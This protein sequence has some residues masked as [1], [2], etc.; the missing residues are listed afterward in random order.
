MSTS[1]R[2]RLHFISHVRAPP[3]PFL[4]PDPTIWLLCWLNRTTANRACGTAQA[5]LVAAI[6]SALAKNENGV[7]VLPGHAEVA[8]VTC[9]GSDDDAKK[10]K[11][12]CD[13]LK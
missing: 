7:S 12:K 8:A 4:Y 13:S 5:Q 3:S 6:G 10:L 1:D 11:E 2:S 9:E